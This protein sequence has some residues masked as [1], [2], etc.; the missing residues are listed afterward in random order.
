MD[1]EYEYRVV[2]QREGRPRRLVTWKS[3]AAARDFIK[4]ANEI[5]SEGH[6]RHI[7]KR[8]VGP[9]ERVEEE[10]DG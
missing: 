7:E 4:L 8:P 2:S 6:A 1:S 10:S 9:W 5:H 3:L